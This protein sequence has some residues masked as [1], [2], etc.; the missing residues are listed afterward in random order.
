MTESRIRSGLIVLFAIGLM[1][2]T[3]RDIALACAA[4]VVVLAVLSLV[5]D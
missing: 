4:A 5:R 3:N 1:V 2:T